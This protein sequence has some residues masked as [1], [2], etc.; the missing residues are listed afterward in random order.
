MAEMLMFVLF[1]AINNSALNEI[2]SR[3]V[4]NLRWPFH[5][6]NDWI[7]TYLVA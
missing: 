4:K 2:C 3:H 1:L 6:E 5:R 7:L